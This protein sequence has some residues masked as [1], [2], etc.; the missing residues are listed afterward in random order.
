MRPQ[1]LL[2]PM[3]SRRRVRNKLQAR[4]ELM[5]RFRAD[6]QPTAYAGDQ[7]GLVPKRLSTG[8]GD[9]SGTKSSY[10]GAARQVKREARSSASA[11]KPPMPP[12]AGI[13][14]VKIRKPKL[15]LFPKP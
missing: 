2:G 3:G 15:R 14:A 8:I 11:P 13:A 6:K 9:A 4:A 1:L 10:A 5:L 12:S 7:T